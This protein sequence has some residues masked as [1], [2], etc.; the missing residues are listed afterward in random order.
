MKGFLALLLI[1]TSSASAQVP[2]MR[3][4]ITTSKGTLTVEGLSEN[5]NIMPKQIKLAAK[6]VEFGDIKE[7]IVMN[8]RHKITPKILSSDSKTVVLMNF[9][10]EGPNKV[11]I[12]AQDR[13]GK[14]MVFKGQFLIYS[15]IVRVRMRKL[16][17]SGDVCGQHKIELV[18]EGQSLIKPI[19]GRGYSN[20]FVFFGVP[21]GRFIARA[22]VGSASGEVKFAVGTKDVTV[23]VPVLSVNAGDKCDSVDPI[24]YVK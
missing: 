1:F 4:K 5:Y 2:G 8:G 9:L 18:R 17:G 12:K 15:R 14:W 20:G 24:D 19:V 7:M 21:T 11:L 22:T 23:E 13:S 10:V 16:D 3:R 6:G